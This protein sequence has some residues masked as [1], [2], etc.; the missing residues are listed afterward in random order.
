MQV[1]QNEEEEILVVAVELQQLQQDIQVGVAQASTALAHLGDLCVIDDGRIIVAVVLIDRNGTINPHR[2]LIEKVLIPAIHVLVLGR[3]NDVLGQVLAEDPF[4]LWC[5]LEQHLGQDK[6]AILKLGVVEVAHI[7]Y[8][9]TS[10]DIL[11]RVDAVEH[12]LQP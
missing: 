8:R 3:I 9:D 6:D 5:V 12:F 4:T 2:E 7:V 10:L 11:E 1:L